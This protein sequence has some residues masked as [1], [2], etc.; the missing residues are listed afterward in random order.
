MPTFTCINSFSVAWPLWVYRQA[1]DGNSLSFLEGTGHSTWYLLSTQ[2]RK[3]AI[4]LVRTIEYLLLSTFHSL[5]WDSCLKCY[6]QTK[7]SFLKNMNSCVFIMCYIKTCY[8]S[9]LHI[10]SIRNFKAILSEKS[11]STKTQI[12]LT[13]I[14]LP[15]LFSSPTCHHTYI[16]S[17]REIY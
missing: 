9:D 8:H 11:S 16:K 12:L 15:I 2:L 17:P 5:M 6:P 13:S 3:W 1:A 7:A 14:C 4:V 10:L